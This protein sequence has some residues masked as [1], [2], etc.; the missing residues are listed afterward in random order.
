MISKNEI[1]RLATEKNV[2][3]STIDKDWVLAHFID[4]IYS[5]PECR[6]TLIFKGGTCLKKCRIADYRFSEDLDFTSLSDSFVFD[7]SLLQQ[8]VSLVENRTE[9]SLY[10]QSIEELLFNNK[11]TGYAARIKYWGADHRKDQQPPEPSRWL[12]NIKI[13]II[14]YETMIFGAELKNISHPYSDR[15]TENATNIPVYNIHEVLAEKIRALIQRSYTAPR[16]YYDIWYLSKYMEDIDWQK[17]VD[18][19]KIKTAYKGLSFTGIDQLVNEDN[20]KTLKAAWKNSLEHQIGNSKLP[21]YQTVKTELLI[22]FRR[23]FL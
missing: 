19:F 15:L 10:I 23:I 3:T 17:V 8:I 20:D 1:N 9:M 2:K 5:I 6:K 7:L 11:R 21:D 12:T 16:D 14:L 18:A 4:A 22:L 13:E